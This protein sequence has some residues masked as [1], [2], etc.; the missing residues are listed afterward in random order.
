MNITHSLSGLS[1]VVR[2][3]GG[4]FTSIY[5]HLLSTQTVEEDWE[6]RLVVIP[7]WDLSVFPSSLGYAVERSLGDSWK[8]RCLGGWT[9]YCLSIRTWVPLPSTQGKSVWVC[10]W[11]L[12]VI[13]VC[14]CVCGGG[15]GWGGMDW[16]LGPAGHQFSKSASAVSARDAVSRNKVE[17]YPHGQAHTLIY[18]IYTH[19]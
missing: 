5:Q 19:I 7:I 15:G 10:V 16:S 8:P 6:L 13:L 4:I 18:H 14:V 9:D 17:K 2:N 1:G 3:G 11:A 12:S